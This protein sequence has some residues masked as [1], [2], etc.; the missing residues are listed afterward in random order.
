MRT[1]RKNLA[2]ATV[3][4]ITISVLVSHA[5]E[6]SEASGIRALTTDALPA[7][8]AAGE[9]ETILPYSDLSLIRRQAQFR[10]VAPSRDVSTSDGPFAI[11]FKT[12]F[13]RGVDL[14]WEAKRKFQPAPVLSPAEL[15]RSQ[16]QF[17][18]GSKNMT[19]DAIESMVIRRSASLIRPIRSVSAPVQMANILGASQSSNVSVFIFPVDA[20]EPTEDIVLVFI[21][22]EKNFEYPMSAGELRLMR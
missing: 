5:Q 3:V 21:G 9:Q 12:P 11:A 7:V 19:S 1:T 17:V 16:V 10:N 8:A 2:L 15:N 20:F 18:V 6:T 4:S 13:L 14:V 22:R